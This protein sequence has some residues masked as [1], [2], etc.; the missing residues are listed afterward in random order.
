MG[1]ARCICSTAGF[2]LERL[3]LKCAFH[4]LLNT[5]GGISLSLVTHGLFFVCGSTPM[6]P[7]V[8]LSARGNLKTFRVF[9]VPSTH[10][11]NVS[12]G[13][14]FWLMCV[15]GGSGC[16]GVCVVDYIYDVYRI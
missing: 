11:F 2:H 13:T 8:S 5:S 1:T 4:G 10:S 15:I 12:L 7:S 14:G 16:R 3:S 9:G 6:S